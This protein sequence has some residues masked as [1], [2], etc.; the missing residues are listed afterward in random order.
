MADGSLAEKSPVGLEPRT[1]T[2]DDE[3]ICGA[4]EPH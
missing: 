2:G 1:F 3:I 4:L